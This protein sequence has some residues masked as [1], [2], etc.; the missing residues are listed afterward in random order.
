MRALMTRG[1]LLAG[2]GQCGRFAIECGSPR[3]GRGRRSKAPSHWAKTG[4]A[5]GC[6]RFF[7]LRRSGKTCL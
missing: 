1:P 5:V 7:G 6:A 2:S 4:T 3:R